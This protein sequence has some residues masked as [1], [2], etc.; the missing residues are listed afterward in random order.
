MVISIDV[1]FDETS[2]IQ[3]LAPKESSVET[4]QKVDNQVEFET[5]LALNSNEQSVPI[6]SVP[7]QQ[8]SISRYRERRTIKPPHKY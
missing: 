3:L 6:A 8:Y 5:G 4:V 1:L 7:V 2:M